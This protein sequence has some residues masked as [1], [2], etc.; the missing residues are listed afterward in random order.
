MSALVIWGIKCRQPAR[1]CLDRLALMRAL[2]VAPP[3]LMPAPDVG[4]HF[5]CRRAGNAIIAEMGHRF[6]VEMQVYMLIYSL[7]E[8]VHRAEYET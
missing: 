3:I 1:L 5:A 8:V 6:L 7:C 4:S 2:C